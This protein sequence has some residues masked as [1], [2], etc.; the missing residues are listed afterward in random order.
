MRILKRMAPPPLIPRKNV[1]AADGI[2][3]PGATRFSLSCRV[4]PQNGVIALTLGIERSGADTRLRLRFPNFLRFDQLPRGAVSLRDLFRNLPAPENPNE[5][6]EFA[7]GQLLPARARLEV[8]M[9]IAATGTGEDI[10]FALRF[11]Y[12]PFATAASCLR[13]RVRTY[14]EIPKEVTR[15]ARTRA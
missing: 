6:V 8:G 4:K 3:I 9:R 7:A 10:E 15:D 11:D 1:C 2:R 14:L 13:N 12:A 5:L